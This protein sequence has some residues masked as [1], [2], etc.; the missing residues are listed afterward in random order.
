VLEALAVFE[1]PVSVE[2]TAHVA[3]L[4]VEACAQAGTRLDGEA[5]VWSRHFQDGTQFEIR[6]ALIR[7]AVLEGLDRQAVRGLHDR[8]LQFLEAMQAAGV[9]VRSAEVAYHALRS[10]S[11]EQALRHAMLAAKEAAD[12]H[13][14]D[15][16]RRYWRAA[17][18]KS[19]E[20]RDLDRMGRILSSMAETEE[21]LGEVEE[22]LHSLE[23]LRGMVPA[24]VKLLVRIGD[25]HR[26]QGR[27]DEAEQTLSQALELAEG[28]GQLQVCR[29]ERAIANCLYRRGRYEES[30][31]RL[32]KAASVLESHGETLELA[33]TMTAIGLIHWYQGDLDQAQKSHE[34]G[35]A[36]YLDLRDQVGVATSYVN[37]GLVLWNRGRLKDALS[38]YRKAERIARHVGH[39]LIIAVALHNRGI[40]EFEM[41]ALEDARRTLTSSLQ[42]RRRL[43]DRAGQSKAMDTLGLVHQHA[44]RYREALRLIKESIA[45]RD[46]LGDRHGTANSQVNLGLVYL[47]LWELTRARELFLAASKAAESL[48]ARSV[49]GEALLGLAEVA[50]RQGDPAAGQ[51]LA[52]KARGVFKRLGQEPDVAQAD[53][54]LVRLALEG[55]GPAF[56]RQRLARA[57]RRLR[58]SGTAW[59][60]A[61]ARFLCGRVR[62]RRGGLYSLVAALRHAEGSGF[63]ELCWRIQLSLGEILWEEGSKQQ[64]ARR[65][66]Q[67]MLLLRDLAA[68]IPEEFFEAYFLDP[69]KQRLKQALSRSMAFFE[70]PAP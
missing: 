13:A 28:E 10:S 21:R 41:G 36:L 11:Q 69:D 53:L 43:Q 59:L 68:E 54:L 12:L 27:Y 39:Y 58:R 57:L 29:V 9:T 60:A 24:S 61:Q 19:E 51:V 5:L 47:D 55:E 4:S 7:R 2:M 65:F 3:D 15:R 44:G 40:I 14:F 42:M 8:S 56:P 63:R 50:V 16:A 20:L 46:R 38:H 49:L 52:F 66:K 17:L 18:E 22:A 70:V 48:G 67:G 37:I 26:M 34:E 31:G 30:L 35:L 6:N 62:G 23:R 45:G 32:Q 64:A 33:R 25:L 1:A